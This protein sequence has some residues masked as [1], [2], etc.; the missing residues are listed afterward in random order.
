[1]ELVGLPYRESNVISILTVAQIR[2]IIGPN[3]LR[4]GIRQ[5]TVENTIS[6]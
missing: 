5:V 3:K 1:M 6:V 4:S 2:K